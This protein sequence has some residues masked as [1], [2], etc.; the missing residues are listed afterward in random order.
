MGWGEGLVTDAVADCVD[1]RIE[2]QQYVVVP[3]TQYPEPLRL[4][5]AGASSITRGRM[6]RAV[7]LDHQ[8][9]G[10]AGEVGDIRRNRVLTAKLE[11]FQLATTQALP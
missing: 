1:N 8:L 10:Q 7:K 4:K 5:V 11:A 9:F 3:E 2:I 6:L